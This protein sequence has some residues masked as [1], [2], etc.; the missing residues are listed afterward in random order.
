MFVFCK[1][2][3]SQA[4]SRK[5]SREGAKNR[6]GDAFTLPVL[7]L[8]NK[9]EENNMKKIQITFEVK[10]LDTVSSVVAKVEKLDVGTILWID[11]ET[12]VD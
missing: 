9:Q 1:V 2:V 3:K 8:S 11:T 5:R 4:E 7:W 10:T 12:K 6:Y